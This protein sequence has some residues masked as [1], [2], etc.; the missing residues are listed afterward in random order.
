MILID[1][2]VT[3]DIGTAFGGGSGTLNVTVSIGSKTLTSGSISV[4]SLGNLLSFNISSLNATSTPYNL[5]C[6]ANLN[7]QTFYANTSLSYLPPN[8]YGGNTVK[9]DRRS[10]ALVVRNET[11]GQKTWTRIIPYGWYDVSEIFN[12]S[13]QRTANWRR[14][15]TQLPIRLSMV[16]TS[17][18]M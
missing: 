4:G 9:V 11:A 18:K 16:Q 13:E 14:A 6:T 5:T 10:G 7:G 15:I 1:A 3:N 12:H 17:A 2:N 8:P